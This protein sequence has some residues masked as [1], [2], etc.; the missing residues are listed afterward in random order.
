MSV[1][2]ALVPVA[3]TLRLVMGKENFNQWIESM[4]ERVPSNFKNELELVRTVRKAGYDAE[5]W[6]GSIK[7]HIDGENMFFF[8]EL[9]D[10]KW[11]AVF[12]KSDSKS[13]LQSFMTDINNAAGRNI[14]GESPVQV[15]ELAQGLSATE[16]T[17]PATIFPT[18]FRNGELLFR[19]LKEFG[20]NPIWNGDGMTCKVEHTKL[21]FLQTGDGPFHVEIQDAP[22]LKKV[23]EYLSDVDDDYR[24]CLQSVVYER[25]KARVNEKNMTIESEE[26]LDDNSIV[27]TLNIRS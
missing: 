5:K 27:L 26:V 15:Q 11:T 25:L 10:G 19:T 8:W 9:I 13:R 20:V 12:S 22:D 7:T 18:N 1:S 23:F 4:Q 24:R 2:L 6:G 16:A 3:L 17:K 21:K 14:F